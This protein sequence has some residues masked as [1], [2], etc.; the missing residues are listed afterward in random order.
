[1]EM[2][3]ELPGENQADSAWAGQDRTQNGEPGI[4]CS[5]LGPGH[6]FTHSFGKCLLDVQILSRSDT[7]DDGGGG[8]D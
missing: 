7:G 5:K 2:T 8:G 4:L 3:Q 1:M 6:S